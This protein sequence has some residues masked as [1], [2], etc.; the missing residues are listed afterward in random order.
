MFQCLL[1]A[2]IYSQHLLSYG[3][4]GL[5]MAPFFVATFNT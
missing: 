4:Q 1:T 2:N 5:Q 3:L